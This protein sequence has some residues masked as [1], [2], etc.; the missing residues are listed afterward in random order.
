ML[1]SLLRTDSNAAADYLRTR[2]PLRT[3]EIDAR[4]I[5]GWIA[6]TAGGYL[7]GVTLG[8][9]AVGLCMLLLVG[10]LG[11]P[12]P[13]PVWVRIPLLIVGGAVVGLAVGTLQARVLGPIVGG[14]RGWLWATLLA[15]ALASPLEQISA[16]A[17]GV[18]S[19]ADVPLAIMLIARVCRGLLVGG[20][21]SR[22]LRQWRTTAGWWIPTTIIASVTGYLFSN[23]VVR[24]AT[25][26]SVGEYVTGYLLSGMTFAVLT[27]VTLL[28]LQRKRAGGGTIVPAA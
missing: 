2:F 3:K 13:I 21:Q 7:L 5:A 19:R 18:E 15:Y 27:S 28:L 6:A 17:T 8:A 14:A 25:P 26:R 20:L 1:L 10:P 11:V 24:S 12:A 9:L 16:I 22:V 23:A 4:A